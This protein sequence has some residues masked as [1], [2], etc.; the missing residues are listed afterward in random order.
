[1]IRFHGTII[2]KKKMLDDKDNYY[3][4]SKSYG[5]CKKDMI[6]PLFVDEND[7]F[8]E[9]NVMP[10]FFKVP[11]NDII[12]CL[13]KIVEN[14]IHS[15]LLFGLPRVRNNMGTSATSNKGIVQKSLRLIKSNFGNKIT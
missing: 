6:F 3:E 14:G 7:R 11:Y 15:V 9:L 10:G 8:Q 2:E 1:M 5:L 12:P 13:E 4:F